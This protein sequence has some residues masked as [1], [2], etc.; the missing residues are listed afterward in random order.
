MFIT[1]RDGNELLFSVHTF[2]EIV[3]VELSSYDEVMISTMSTPCFKV[4]L[5][6][7]SPQILKTGM[8]FQVTFSYLW[9]SYKNSLHRANNI[10]VTL[11]DNKGKELA[12]GVVYEYDEKRD[13]RVVELRCKCNMAVELKKTVDIVA[14][15]NDL[16]SYPYTKEIFIYFKNPLDNNSTIETYVSFG[17]CCICL[18]VNGEDD[19]R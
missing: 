14:G 2:F 19:E 5:F 7:Q 12:K 4:S 9:Q 10:E 11:F 3:D 6:L 8:D 18:V 13:E 1:V 17:N 16:C 15:H